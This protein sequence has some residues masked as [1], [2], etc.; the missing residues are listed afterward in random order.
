MTFFLL[1]VKL[2]YVRVSRQVRIDWQTNARVSLVCGRLKRGAL[3]ISPGGVPAPSRS[4]LGWSFQRTDVPPLP[5]A[6]QALVHQ[7]WAL[8]TDEATQGFLIFVPQPISTRPFT[9]MR[10]FGP[11]C[12][13][14]I[15]TPLTVCPEEEKSSSFIQGPGLGL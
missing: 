13:L 3:D 5:V 9:A 1:F 7:I 15:I 6:L 11:L 4:L 10:C 14:H 2:K 8:K 12:T